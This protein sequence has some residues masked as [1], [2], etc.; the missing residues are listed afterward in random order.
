MSVFRKIKEQGVSLKVTS[1]VMLFVSI[2]ITSVLI[3]SSAKAFR[4]FMS[5][6]KSTN[7]YI[8][9]EEEAS[10]LMVASDYLTEQVQC[11]TV[12]GDRKYLDNYF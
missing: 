1:T 11:Y 10:K 12:M 7:E 8:T 9:L 5:L 3:F 6:E 4:N 2:G